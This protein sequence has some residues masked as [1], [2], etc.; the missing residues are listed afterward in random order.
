MKAVACF[1]FCK[2]VKGRFW[3]SY[4]PLRMMMAL[5]VIRSRV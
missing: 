1:D 2:Q 4:D 5:S 3:R